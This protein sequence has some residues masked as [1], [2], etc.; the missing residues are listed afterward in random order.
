MY[1]AMLMLM[2]NRLLIAYVQMI[3]DQCVLQMA[4]PILTCVLLYVCKL[5]MNTFIVV[6]W[7]VDFEVEKIVYYTIERLDQANILS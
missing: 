4:R 1:P 3:T 5:S 2:M 7:F 6:A